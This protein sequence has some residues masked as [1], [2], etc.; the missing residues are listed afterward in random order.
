MAALL[1]RTKLSE[2]SRVLPGR[3]KCQL[4][5]YR[6]AGAEG[7]FCLLEEGRVGRIGL[8]EE[9]EDALV[10]VCKSGWGQGLVRLCVGL[11]APCHTPE[12]LCK[13]AGELKE[14]GKDDAPA[15]KSPRR[16]R[17][18]WI[19]SVL[20]SFPNSRIYSAAYVSPSWRGRSFQHLRDR[21]WLET[22]KHTASRMDSAFSR[23]PVATRCT[24]LTSSGSSSPALW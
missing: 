19:V 11:L 22:E 13:Q 4:L 18:N 24:S 5:W 9:K 21:I 17:M 10:A 3:Q 1:S 15:I 2:D 14:V 8:R 20:D 16:T 12:R 6:I 23:V 7:V